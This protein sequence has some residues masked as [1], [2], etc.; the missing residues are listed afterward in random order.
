MIFTRTFS[1]SI[2]VLIFL[3]LHFEEGRNFRVK[4]ISEGLDVPDS[5]LAKI[6]QK[7]AKNKLI[8]SHKG[9]NGGFAFN[10]STLKTPLVEIIELTDS[11]DYLNTC[12]LNFH[13]CNAR[14]PCPMHHMVGSINAEI[15]KL[16]EKTCFEELLLNDR[17]LLLNQIKDKNYKPSVLIS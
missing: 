9:P 6:L 10:P 1:Y 15:R 13:A 7:L 8:Q 12:V 3:A 2:K 11:K 16:L 4:D 14:N 17:N 5:F